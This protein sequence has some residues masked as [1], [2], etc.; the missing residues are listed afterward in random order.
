MVPE[1][2]EKNLLLVID[3]LM[4]NNYPLHFIFKYIKIRLK[5]LIS[6]KLNNG[7]FKKRDKDNKF[8]AFLYIKNIIESVSNSMRFMECSTEY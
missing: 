1:F 2:Q 7:K 5:Y 6:T 4:N 8:F 3:M